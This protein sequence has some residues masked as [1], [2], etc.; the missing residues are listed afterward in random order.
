MKIEVEKAVFKLSK[1]DLVNKQISYLIKK[2]KSQ[3]LNKANLNIPSDFNSD[4]KFTMSEIKDLPGA[5]QNLYEYTT[6]TQKESPNNVFS[7]VMKVKDLLQC[8]FVC[9]TV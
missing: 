1:V 6:E 5:I 7:S 3:T 9:K 2:Y 4:I 8:S